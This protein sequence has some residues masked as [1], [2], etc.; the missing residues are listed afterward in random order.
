MRRA[1]CL[2]VALLALLSGVSGAMAGEDRAAPASLDAYEAKAA[3][4]DRAI[5]LD[6]ASDWYYYER[7]VMHREE[8]RGE[9][10]LSD[11]QA[12]VLLA[13]GVE[14]YH[15]ALA[16]MAMEL[17]QHALAEEQYAAALAL[18]PE[19]AI[20]R[21]NRGLMRHALGAYVE[22]IDDFTVLLSA[23]ESAEAR[24][25]R[26]LSRQALG[27]YAESFDDAAALVEAEPD[28]A[29][30]QHLYALA[31]HAKRLSGQALDAARKAAQLA[32]EK[33]EYHYLAGRIAYGRNQVDDAIRHYGD[34]VGLD[35]ENGAYQQALGNC[36]YAQSR[37]PEAVAAYERARDAL[38]DSASVCYNLGLAYYVLDDDASLDRALEALTASIERNNGDA[39][40]FHL[41]AETLLKQADRAPE[42]T[43]DRRAL[44]SLSLADS[45][46]A[47]ALDAREASYRRQ[48]SGILYALGEWERALKDADAAIAMRPEDH[49]YLCHRLL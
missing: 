33:A 31:L 39:A 19:D 16:D 20:Y 18:S 29:D 1:C 10:A 28:S 37:Y 46:Q 14:E 26:A 47:N 12:A 3:D 17:G 22:A 30:N 23:E 15:A 5:A 25:Y 34:A 45:E 9:Q 44:L 2:L 8:G 41:R 35:P 24:Y 40:A 11:F 49:A 42:Q 13:D 4:F 6:G 7:G 38:P 43:P 27:L 36:Y 21:M 32:P 48:R